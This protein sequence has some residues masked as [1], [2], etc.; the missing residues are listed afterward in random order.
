MND[1]EASGS[2]RNDLIDTLIDLK[3]NAVEI[4]DSEL[5]LDMLV[6]QAAV[7]FSAGEWSSII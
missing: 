4:N 3:K 7:F 6:A 2:K 5:T 1:R